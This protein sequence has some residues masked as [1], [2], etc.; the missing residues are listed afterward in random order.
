MKAVDPNKDS[1]QQSSSK[2]K[3]NKFEK[4]AFKSTNW[5]SGCIKID[6]WYHGVKEKASIL[7]QCTKHFK[8]KNAQKL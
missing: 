2:N 3:I 1:D 6:R 4:Q 5:Q 8:A 7:T